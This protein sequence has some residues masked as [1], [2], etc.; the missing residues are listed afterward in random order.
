MSVFDHCEFDGHE[1]V[2]FCHDE[3]F[4]LFAIIGVGSRSMRRM[5]G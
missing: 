1:Q 5:S 2:L 3:R 4:G